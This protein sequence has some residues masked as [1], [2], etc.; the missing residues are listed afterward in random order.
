MGPKEVKPRFHALNT[1][2][3]TRDGEGTTIGM[4]MRKNTNGGPGVRQFVV[5]L[6]DG[7]IRHYSPNELTV[8]K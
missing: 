3:I 4:N 8:K 2:V 7:R 1:R 6:N 5:R